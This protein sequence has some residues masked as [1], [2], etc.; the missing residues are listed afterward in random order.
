MV[1]VSYVF[2]RKSVSIASIG[3]D[4]V[5]N[6]YVNTANSNVRVLKRVPEDSRLLLA[7]TLSDK[8]NDIF[9]KVE[10]VTHWLVFLAFFLFFPKQPQRNGRKQ[11][12]AMSSIL[13]KKN[14][15]QYGFTA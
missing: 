14:R 4:F 3:S 2:K 5:L 10:K 15:N 13:N 1:S 9:Y 8:I 6:S 7:K 12:T 11:T